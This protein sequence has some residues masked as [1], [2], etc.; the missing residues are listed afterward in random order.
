L[1]P[2]NGF[3]ANEVFENK[4]SKTASFGASFCMCKKSNF[5]ITLPLMATLGLCCGSYL[6]VHPLKTKKKPTRVHAVYNISSISI[7]LTNNKSL[8]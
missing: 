8:N 6:A 3:A 7:T 1:W 2:V 4:P 5:L